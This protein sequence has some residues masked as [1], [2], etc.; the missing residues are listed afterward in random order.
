VSPT[1]RRF[2]QTYRGSSCP[3]LAELDSGDTV[4]VK[5]R[6]SGNGTE[7]LLGEYV[8]NRLAHAAGFPV[9]AP[10]IVQL[11]ENF[12]WNYGTD[13]F[14]D[15]VRQSAGSN[16]GL[17][18]IRGARPLPTSR[19]PQIPPNLV[20]QIVTLDRTFSN[21]DRT[22]QSGNLVED[23]TGQVWFVDHGSCRFLQEG[24][25]AVL[26]PLPAHHSFRAQQHAFDPAWLETIDDQ[27]VAAV[28]TEAPAAWL[29][30]V[31][32]TPQ[33]LSAALQA[34]LQ[35]ARSSGLAG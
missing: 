34:R 8:V 13:E 4:V 14:H 10:L 2:I 21:W 3:T 28:A 26:P 12:P 6:G 11:P 22:D 15:L 20:S 1:L 5:L 18:V 25:R 33:N 17:A 24:N 23:D 27:L 9:P 19:Y 32:T 7:A 30:A 35:L 31:G 29:Q 16:L